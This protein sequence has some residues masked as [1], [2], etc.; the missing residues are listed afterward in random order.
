MGSGGGRGTG[1]LPQWPVIG[2]G[3]K[4]MTGCFS[5]HF[6]PGSLAPKDYI[7]LVTSMHVEGILGNKTCG[8]KVDN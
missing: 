4:G 2:I 5:Y 7:S 3:G 8:E 1:L 6:D